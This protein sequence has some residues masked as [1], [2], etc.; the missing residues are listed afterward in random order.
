MPGLL[1]VDFGPDS[2]SVSGRKSAWIGDLGRLNLACV[3]L[4]IWAAFCFFLHR[5]LPL[6]AEEDDDGWA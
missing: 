1:V 3:G 2:S 4:P 5:W 6:F